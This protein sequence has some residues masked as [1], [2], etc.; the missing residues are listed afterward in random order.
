MQIEGPFYNL[1]GAAEYCGYRS[2]E[3]FSELL[4]D[5]VV[6][7]YGPK[8]N[9]YARSVLDAWMANPEAFKAERKSSRPYKP[10]RVTA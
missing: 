8:K 2:P 5:F 10:S 7:K 6:P 9:R 1:E 3:H 4:G